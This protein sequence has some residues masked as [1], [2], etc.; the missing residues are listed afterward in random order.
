MLDL[1]PTARSLGTETA[2][3]VLARANAL[4]AEGRSI[5][6]LGIGQPDFRTADH[7]VEAAIKALRDGHHGYTPAPGILPLRA[8]VA[9]DLH[10]R[11]GL[12]VDPGRIVCV[13]GGKVTIWFACLALGHPGVEIVYPDPGFPIYRS[14]AAFTG[15]TAVP[16][17]LRE[18]DG[19]AMTADGLARVMSDKTRLVILNTPSNPLGALTPAE[20]LARIAR[21]LADYPKAAI[22]SDEIYGQMTYGG[23]AHV[24]LLSFPEVAD[25]VILLDGWSKTYAMT[26]W[27]LGYAVWPQELVEAA[28]RL[29][30]NS[31][32]CVNAPT[33]FA[34]IAALE[35]PQDA[36]ATMVAAFAER[37]RMVLDRLNALPGVH[38]PEPHG[39][40][41]AFPNVTGTGIDAGVLQDRLLTEAGVALISGTSFGAAGAGY[42]RLSYAADLAALEDGIGRMAAFLATEAVSGAA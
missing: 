13:P 17:V 25:R 21:L 32:S 8:A 38:C 22:L 2:F 4:A 9:A 31:H 15:A 20:E 40:F 27:R 14:A 30:V 41:Y 6:N 28:I 26:G 10:R 18:E 39:A 16:M 35:G 1:A 19:F 11:L 34:G 33:Q 23:A 12:E 24:S 7:I 5:V 42:L 37:R 3:D 29:C 36:V